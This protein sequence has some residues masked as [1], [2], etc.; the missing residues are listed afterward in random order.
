MQKSQKIDAYPDGILQV[1]ADDGRCLI[2]QKGEIAFQRETVGYKRFY[3]A[4][5]SLEAT[6]IDKLVKVPRC[7]IA[8][9]SD[10][11]TIK[12]ED[13]VQYR[14][15]RIQEVPGSLSDRWEL[16]AVKVS[17]EVTVNGED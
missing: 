4:K 1:W 3:N 9:R 6:R 16:E 10:I 15:L 2:R 13:G 17:M 12:G 11:V 7:A 5:E 8:N 14:I